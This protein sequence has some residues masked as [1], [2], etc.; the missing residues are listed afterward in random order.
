[1]KSTINSLKKLAVALGCASKVEDVKGNS[2]ADVIDF[3]AT[4][5]PQTKTTITKNIQL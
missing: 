2:T 5:L 1:M 4:H 3:I